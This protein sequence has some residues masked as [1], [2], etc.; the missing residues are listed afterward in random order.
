MIK[1]I[2]ANFVGRFWSILSNFLFIPLYI[3]YLGFENYSVI[4]FTL[5][6]AGVMAVLD[7]GL[8]A[9]L[10]R[11]FARSDYELFEKIKVYRTLETVYYI[12]VFL[13]ILSVI[14]FSG[15][16]AENWL[17]L[18]SHTPNEIAFLLK[19][20]GF[21]IGFQLLFRFYLGGLLGLEMQVKANIV[22]VGWG[23]MRNG[24]VV[25]WLLFFPTL[26][27]FFIWQATITV[28][29]T[30]IIKL[31]LEKILLGQYSLKLSINIDRQVLMRVWHFAGGMLLISLVAAINT[32]MDKLSISKFLALDNLGYYNLAIS[33]SQVLVVL[34][35]PIAA[36][37]SPRFTSFYTS[38]KINEAKNLFLKVGL[39]VSIFI[40]S[41]M[42]NLSLFSKDLLWIWTGDMVIAENT[43]ILI[44]IISF[45][46]SML[47]LQVIPFHIAL[48]N[49]Y[50]KL[51]N[52][53]GLLSLIITI[54]GYFFAIRIYGAI[55]AAVVFCIVQTLTTIIYIYFINK[56]F[57]KVNI[58]KEIYF[59]HL[60][61]P[62]VLSLI[63]G[64][65]LSLI[66]NPFIENRVL[67]LL[68]IGL[69]TLFTLSIM[70]LLIL[71]FKDI[72]SF[73]KIK[74]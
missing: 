42:I 29:F 19:I 38:N 59:K 12:I 47:A 57:I 68:W 66:P 14:L 21:D 11:E 39:F 32:Q 44:P 18:N 53:I 27:V 40:F 26:E 45:S 16:I 3:Y 24:F 15:V 10:S 60:F 28:F 37:L 22:Q 4:S 6:I 51:N 73:L 63:I 48:A 67:S 61:L 31:L 49:G 50:T 25:L 56:K 9:T 17:N 69:A 23:M 52:L 35:N 5:V 7:A 65:I 20:I 71:P 64:F 54:P 43:Y 30:F 62:I 70:A 34:V 46:Y 2:I 8:T 33:L 13:S 36:A 58:F 1:N 41:I 74:K 55:G 72:I